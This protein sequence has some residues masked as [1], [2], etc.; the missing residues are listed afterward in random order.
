M[1][2]HAGTTR[3]QAISEKL[4]DQRFAFEDELR[5]F[6]GMCRST[7]GKFIGLLGFSA[8]LLFVVSRLLKHQRPGMVSSVRYRGVEPMLTDGCLFWHRIG[9]HAKVP[10]L[11]IAGHLG[12]AGAQRRCN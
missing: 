7:L 12:I 5:P 10:C 11:R 4:G 3:T 1:Q 6:F 9:L 2:R 8:S